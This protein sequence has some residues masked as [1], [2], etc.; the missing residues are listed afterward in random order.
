MNSDTEVCTGNMHFYSHTPDIEVMDGGQLVYD[1]IIVH[2]HIN[3]S[4]MLMSY[5]MG[6][7]MQVLDVIQLI[8]VVPLAR[9]RG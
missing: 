8:K 7:L 2:V 5:I 9:R 1:G 4:T 6:E 3:Q